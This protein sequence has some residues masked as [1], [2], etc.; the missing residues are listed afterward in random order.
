MATQAQKLAAMETVNMT[1]LQTA[2]VAEVGAQVTQ[3][4]IDAEIVAKFTDAD[5]SMRARAAS[6]FVTAIDA[7]KNVYDILALDPEDVTPTP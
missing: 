5:G 3:A 1:T 4:T 2:V 6:F 7:Y